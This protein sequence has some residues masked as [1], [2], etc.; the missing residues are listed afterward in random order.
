MENS[1]KKRGVKTIWI[2][3]IQNSFW[4]FKQI[5]IFS[6]NFLNWHFWKLWSPI[7]MWFYKLEIEPKKGGII[8]STFR[9][10]K[11]QAIQGTLEK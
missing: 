5:P 10:N 3:V 1:P 4:I 9:V 11:F 2:C 8:K 7:F 6:L